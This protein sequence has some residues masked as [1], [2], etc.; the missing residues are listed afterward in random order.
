MDIVNRHNYSLS[1]F[2]TIEGRLQTF[3]NWPSTHPIKP[4]KLAEAG[5]FSTGN[6]D[7]V[8][9]FKCNQGLRQFEAEDDPW[10]EHARWFPSCEFVKEKISMDRENAEFGILPAIKS[11]SFT[12]VR[13]IINQFGIFWDHFQFTDSKA[14]VRNNPNSITKKDNLNS[15]DKT[16]CSLCCDEERDILFLPCSHLITCEKCAFKLQKCPNCRV[17]ITGFIHVYF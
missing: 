5:L 10:T 17:K 4:L 7:E 9:C 11:Y 13:S 8:Y 3:E 16:I 2:S 1:D 12:L 6:G 15:S 14:L